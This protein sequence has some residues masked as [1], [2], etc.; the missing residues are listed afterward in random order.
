[1]NW[2]AAVRNYNRENIEGILD[3]TIYDQ[4]QFDQFE[5]RRCSSAEVFALDFSAWRHHSFYGLHRLRYDPRSGSGEHKLRNVNRKPRGIRLRQHR[6]K[7]RFRKQL[8]IIWIRI[9]IQ[10]GFKLR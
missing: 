7:L 3:A 8:G 6:V 9:I 1:M 4:V 5:G 10:F 2:E